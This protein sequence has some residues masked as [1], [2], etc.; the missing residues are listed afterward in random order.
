MV[1]VEDDLL[2]AL[3][4][5]E[6]EEHAII[7]ARTQ[8]SEVSLAHSLKEV[9]RCVEGVRRSL[10]E[11]D[12][13]SK[14]A[15]ELRNSIRKTMERADVVSVKVRELDLSRSRALEALEHASRCVD[16]RKCV[17]GAR[18]ALISKELE[19]AAGYVK[20][21]DDISGDQALPGAVDMQTIRTELESSIL[22]ASHGGPTNSALSF[23]DDL[24]A[25]S[26][27]SIR[28][29]ASSD[30]WMESA[31]LKE[32]LK[33][34]SVMSKVSD[35]SHAETKYAHFL[36]TYLKERFL[37]YFE[38]MGLNSV[39]GSKSAPPEGSK[40]F[41]ETLKYLFNSSCALIDANI[42]IPE[43][44]LAKTARSTIFRSV[45]SECDRQCTFLF[46]SYI[47]TRRL[48][49]RASR[50]GEEKDL[51]KSNSMLNEMCIVMQHVETYDR[52]VRSKLAA[53]QISDYNPEYRRVVQE[54]AGVYTVL[55]KSWLCESIKRAKNAE[56]AVNVLV[57]S[58]NLQASSLVEDSFYVSGRSVRRALGTG[59]SDA[60]CGCINEVVA[61]LEDT[62]VPQFSSGATSG[63]LL[64]WAQI[65]SLELC[66]EYSTKLY[67]TI[68]STDSFARS[69][70]V[71]KVKSCADGLLES[72]KVFEAKR[73]EA[74]KR[75]L[76]TLCTIPAWK[77]GLDVLEHVSYQLDEAGFDKD[78]GSMAKLAQG[79]SYVLGGETKDSISDNSFERLVELCSFRIAEEIEKAIVVKR[80]TQLGALRFE[81]DV[82]QICEQLVGYVT[83]SLG[84]RGIFARLFQMSSILNVVALE[85]AHDVWDSFVSSSANRPDVVVRSIRPKDKLTSKEVKRVLAL[86]IDF[87]QREVQR[88]KLL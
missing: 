87:D 80:F 11:L 71:E 53:L 60:A 25:P 40:V 2:T 3:A 4:R 34:A 9:D 65:N 18:E 32:A 26:K 82:R 35:A 20:R 29:Q 66:S 37:A 33:Q 12:L 50:Q 55:E 74:L 27:K 84:I 17:K 68:V 70:D 19:V 73:V 64:E 16:A 47:S 86:R 21:F 57:S 15:G 7:E 6:R 24:A 63:N 83:N 48:H 79:V 8:A 14:T 54:V 22:E 30:L 44:V 13:V 45:N 1:S 61:C 5:L 62:A 46:D 31:A 51:A 36:A 28:E 38:K 49:E 76:G 56:N 41:V 67:E 78:D 39:D 23:D 10:P 77:Q 43:S 42:R 52:F 85:E 72:S 75:E 58:R 88:M 69:D 81:K 59:S